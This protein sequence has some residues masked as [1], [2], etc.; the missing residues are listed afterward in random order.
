MAAA[1]LVTPAQAG[2]PLP[3]IAITQERDSR[4]RGNDVVMDNDHG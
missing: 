2:V 1:I 3:F 4:V